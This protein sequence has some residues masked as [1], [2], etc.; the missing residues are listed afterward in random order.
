MAET[1]GKGPQ[2]G[3]LDTGVPLRRAPAPGSDS[4]RLPL[5]HQLPKEALASHGGQEA[6]SGDLLGP[7]GDPCPTALIT[8]PKPSA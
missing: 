5:S 1:Q 4:G 6:H 8:T 2:A 3:P 7:A